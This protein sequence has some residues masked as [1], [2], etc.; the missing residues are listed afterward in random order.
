MKVWVIHWYGKEVPVVFTS[1]EKLDEYIQATKED[2]KENYD[3][4]EDKELISDMSNY[5][6][7]NFQMEAYLS[8]T[9]TDYDW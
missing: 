8:E 9:E 2:Y 5:A 1:K 3:D 6:F 4:E 7:V